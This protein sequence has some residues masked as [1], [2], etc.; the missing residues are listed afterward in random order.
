VIVA[1]PEPALATYLTTTLPS[2][3]VSASDGRT[4]PRFVV[5]E[6]CVPLCGGVPL[7]SITCAMMLVVP[8]VEAPSPAAVNVMVDPLGASSGTLSHA[9]VRSEHMTS[10]GVIAEARRRRGIM[11]AI[12]S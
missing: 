1:V 4:I 7:A 5:K 10:T 11:K 8:L 2:I 3:S 12:T 6:M 9:A